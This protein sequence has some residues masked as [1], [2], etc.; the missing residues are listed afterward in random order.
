MRVLAGANRGM[1]WVVGT[2]VH[3]CWL[4]TYESDTQGVIGAHVRAGSTIFDIGANAGFYSLAFSR[5]CGPS[6]S[7]WA[8]E[9]LAENVA[10]LLRH[11]QINHLQNVTVVQ[12][13]LSDTAGFAGF[14]VAENNSMGSLSL[15]ATAYRVPTSTLDEMIS[16]HGAPVPD[17]VK[18]DVEGAEHAVLLGASQLLARR[19]AT[20]LVALHGDTQCRD[21]VVA[22]ESNGY[23]V[24]RIDGSPAG[25]RAEEQILAVPAPFLRRN[26]P[27]PVS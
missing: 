12:A 24:T 1:K 10:N 5:M 3:G 9:P 2:S 6:G 15:S 14:H 13:A 4:G 16:R 26:P 21:C 20:W 23:S 11:V 17:F 19:S 18:M 27:R 22:F 8:F 25:R 7:V